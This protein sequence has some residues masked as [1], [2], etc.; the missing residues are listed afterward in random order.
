MQFDTIADTAF[1]AELKEVFTSA[2]A[3]KTL[4][5]S[6]STLRIAALSGAFD[7][8]R[9]HLRALLATQATGTDSASAGLN[10]AE[11]GNLPLVRA[12]ASASG[13]RNFVEKL[14][15]PDVIDLALQTSS[16]H[17]ATKVVGL[18]LLRVSTHLKPVYVSSC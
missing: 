14:T 9:C 18:H 6:V 8:L 4:K 11:L 10:L 1:K 3:R 5:K 15:P 2:K 17:H 7:F 16:A 13:G 12:I